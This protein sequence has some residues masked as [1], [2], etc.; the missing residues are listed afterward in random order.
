MKHAI[1]K[2]TPGRTALVVAMVG[3]VAGTA[4][5][6][7]PDLSVLGDAFGSVEW[8]WVAA[9]FL[10]NVVSTWL[11]ALAWQVALEQAIPEPYPT[12]RDVFSA[13]SVGL[14]G[15]AVLPGRVGE[16]ARVGVLSRRL[17]QGSRTWPA[18]AGSIF[19]HRVF[20]VL[21]TAGLAAYVLVSARLPSWAAPGVGA[22]LAIGGALLLAAILLACR[23]APIH[24]AE[25]TGR[26]RTAMLMVRRGL[27]V[28]RAPGS[29]ISASVLQLSAWALQLL[30]VWLALRAF[31]IQE[32]IAAAALVLLVI[33][34]AL[35]FPL[36]PGS[37]GLY[38]AAVALALLPYG[39]GYDHGF[40][41]GIG[42]QAIETAVGVGLGLIFLAR[43]GVSFAA[44]KQMP[45]VT[46]EHVAPATPGE[47][48]RRV[49][50]RLLRGRG[51]APRV[52]VRTGLAKDRAAGSIHPVGTVASSDRARQA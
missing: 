50:W 5:W 22:V 4:I 8:R 39:I 20:D 44:L 29:A 48:D 6:T 52:P 27:G 19:A 33:N 17:P 40:A 31:G 7:A 35:A 1:L 36:W 23:Q 49:A 10:A 9:A 51:P 45:R 41:A 30:A 42:I 15:N 25:Q 14:L 37:V 11:R 32:P 34:V 26:L 24:D 3:V 47:R 16:F 46:G 18:V 2:T 21:P 28:F 43:E 38:Q 13:F 12:H